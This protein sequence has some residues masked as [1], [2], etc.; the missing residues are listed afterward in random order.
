M[1]RRTT[2]AARLC[3]SPK[4]SPAYNSRYSNQSKSAGHAVPAMS[5]HTGGHT[6]QLV[7]FYARGSAA[8][9][10]TDAVIGQDP[11]RGPYLDNTSIQRVVAG[12][13]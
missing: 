13:W 1:T 3:R 6:S 11:V 5:W 2:R 9:A 8:P 12:L 10:F 4:R 7:P